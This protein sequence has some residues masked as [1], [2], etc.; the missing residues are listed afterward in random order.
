M[1]T[2]PARWGAWWGSMKGRAVDRG[3]MGYTLEPM[4]YTHDIMNHTIG[5]KMV[6]TLR[7]AIL[8]LLVHYPD[9]A[10]G[11]MVGLS[12]MT[13]KSFCHRA[14]HQGFCVG[15]PRGRNH[16]VLGIR[17]LVTHASL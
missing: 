14:P 10:V 6:N 1:V 17:I 8:G 11:P 4:G 13:L 9:L 12:S 2:T 15:A 7:F 5:D 16:G 3:P